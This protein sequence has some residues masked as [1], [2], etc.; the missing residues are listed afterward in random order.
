MKGNGSTR[1]GSK[2]GLLLSVPI[3]V[4]CFLPF[5]RDCVSLLVCHAKQGRILLLVI[6]FIIIAIVIVIIIS[7]V[8]SNVDLPFTILKSPSPPLIKLCIYKLYEPQA[9]AFLYLFLWCRQAYSSLI[10]SKCQMERIPR[11]SRFPTFLLTKIRIRLCGRRNSI[12]TLT[13]C[14]S[15]WMSRRL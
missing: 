5:L 11:D 7:S 10:M 3:P 4:H 9:Q 2:N 1:Q 14:G 6:A 15:I 12:L 8:I 13:W